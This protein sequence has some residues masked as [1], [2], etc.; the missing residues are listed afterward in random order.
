[1]NDLSAP[2]RDS[3]ASA[4]Q[5]PRTNAEWANRRVVTM[6]AVLAI[7]V[8]TGLLVRSLLFPPDDQ[9]LGRMT[10]RT[11]LG[12][13]R[14]EVLAWHSLDGAHALDMSMAATRLKGDDQKVTAELFRD[15]C[16]AVLTKLPDRSG[17]AVARDRIYRLG[18]QVYTSNGTYAPVF[19]VAVVDG[20]CMPDGWPVGHWAYPLALP[21]VYVRSVALPKLSEVDKLPAVVFAARPGIAMAADAFDPMAACSAVLADPPPR[22]EA[23]LRRN[24]RLQISF[25]RGVGA[26]V[27]AIGRTWTWAFLVSNGACVQSQAGDKT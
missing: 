18:V 3:P 7:L 22:V 4:P 14:G 23:S 19:P 20:V 26:H 24:G 10:F 25:W 1:M 9:G 15:L 11:S 21:Q 17:Q 6:V 12:E 13:F 27:F 5:P 8:P 16:G 2:D